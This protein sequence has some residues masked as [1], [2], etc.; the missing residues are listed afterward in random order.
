M[1]LVQLRLVES[2]VD[3]LNVCRD[4]GQIL[5]QRVAESLQCV[6]V[7]LRSDHGQFALLCLHVALQLVEL[8]VQSIDLGGK[9]L[10][11]G[12]SCRV[13]CLA[14]VFITVDESLIIL[15]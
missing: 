6:D 8:G 9:C 3:Y 7:E 4:L 5:L 2:S 14:I 1:E 12:C 11:H 10:E 13:L 15:L